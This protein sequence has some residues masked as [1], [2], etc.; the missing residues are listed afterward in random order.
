[1]GSELI[2][3]ATQNGSQIALLEDK[4]LVEFHEEHYSDKFNVG[5]IYLGKVRRVVSGLNA[6][7]VDIGHAKDAFLHYLDLGE[8]FPSLCSYVNKLREGSSESLS[9]LSLE[10]SIDKEGKISD[11]LTKRVYSYSYR[12]RKSLSRRK[13]IGSLARSLCLVGILS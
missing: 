13:V 6:A 2:I 11:V 8:H 12:S 7:F 9:E 10:E 5:D 3:R 1:M 4:Q